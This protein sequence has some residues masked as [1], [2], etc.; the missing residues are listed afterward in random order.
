[1][2]YERR[3]SLEL[4]AAGS[5][6]SPRLVGY[7][8]VYDSPA[9]L[10]EFVEVIKPGA[11]T[12][13]LASNA[14]DQV[15]LYH[16]KPELILGRRSAGTLRLASDHHGLK[17]EIDLPPTQTGRDLAISCERGDVRGCSFAF[18]VPQGGD[19]WDVRSGRA[20]RE[21][22]DIDLHEVTVT[23]FAAYSDTSVALRA[24]NGRYSPSLYMDHARLWLETV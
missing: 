21:L 5:K 19:S 17:F 1:M 15:A 24:F 9:E 6:D 8:A 10:G 23:P 14:I 11:F 22:R 12:R 7:A 2:E 16:H 18:T 4:R 13:T 20:Q 3:S